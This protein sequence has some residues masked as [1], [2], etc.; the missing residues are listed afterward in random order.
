MA[1]R[2]V[3]A[4]LAVS[5]LLPAVARAGE[6]LRVQNGAV[7]WNR[8]VERPAEP[9]LIVQ[10]A[11]S[12]PGRD[13]RI[14]LIDDPAAVEIL[15]THGALRQWALIRLAGLTW[16]PD[17]SDS[18]LALAAAMDG[19]WQ[20]DAMR[21]RV[22]IALG[23]GQTRRALGTLGVKEPEQASAAD[24]VAWNLA[25]ARLARRAGEAD[26]A[27]ASVMRVIA[28][29]NDRWVFPADSFDVTTRLILDLHGDLDASAGAE[30]AL[31]IAR[32]LVRLGNY[33]D[34]VPFFDTATEGLAGHADRL[35]AALEQS[36]ALRRNSRYT[37]ARQ[38]LRN[39]RAE[40]ASER[41]AVLF[42]RAR[43]E[44]S[45]GRFD[46]ADRIYGEAV[47]E[48][49]RT[50]DDPTLA[51]AARHRADL[52]WA[53]RRW[54]TARDLY[55]RS[56][57]A[58][59]DEEARLR[60]GLLALRT[61]GGDAGY[62]WWLRNGES[63]ESRFWMALGTRRSNPARADSILGIIADDPGFAYRFHQ[64]A[65]RET[66]GLEPR[67]E[68]VAAA[69][70][71]GE[72]PEWLRTA[73]LFLEI[74]AGQAARRVLADALDGG[75]RRSSEYPTARHW[76]R[77]AAIAYSLRDFPVGIRCAFRARW[78]PHKWRDGIETE[79]I[80]P[81]IYPP[82][83]DSLYVREAGKK[84]L[85][86]NL[87]RAIGWQESFYDEDAV[88]RVGALGVMQFM[89]YTA[90]RVAGD[91]GETLHADSLLLE[92]HRS[93]RYSA[94]Y[95]S[96][97]LK[98]YGGRVPLALAAYNAGPGNANRWAART[99]GWSDAFLVECIEFPETRGYVQNILAVRQ[100]YRTYRPR[101]AEDRPA[102]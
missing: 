60:A 29:E 56:W 59:R 23:L 33:S 11:R 71:P 94:H 70:A 69:A 3:A 2:L 92:A 50:P 21:G 86:L 74:G 68:S 58:S 62:A 61:Q 65:A 22:E 10:A 85:D 48:A 89:P 32:A 54:T 34:A 101:W 78:L 100:A 18:L 57:R 27:W 63:P 83:F 24:R 7:V 87:F 46:T 41:A 49:R 16:R 38:L 25:R 9:S 98:R 30:E 96:G 5:A 45:A 72:G 90:K 4:T 40:N 12:A 75:S 80:L 17:R 15:T 55:E 39:L 97:L 66:L 13:P 43:V 64:S 77:A 1:W 8:T 82:A 36:D 99:R 31:L 35:E 28:R 37:Q 95:F 79:E 19:L 67:P 52:A 73:D 42:M 44:R 81:W 76:L 26:T 14:P 53:R 47:E 84:G 102:N 88:S 20:Y 6:F 93:I 91:L 51:D